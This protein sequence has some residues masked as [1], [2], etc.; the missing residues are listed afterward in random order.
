MKKSNLIL[1]PTDFSEASANAFRYA[2]RMAD[3][4]KSEILIVNA[5]I[6][7]ETG[8]EAAVTTLALRAQMEA[9]EKSIARFVDNGLAQVFPNLETAP[10]VTK[11]IRVG[12]AE[13]VIINIAKEQD[14][15]FILIGSRGENRNFVDKLIGSVAADVVKNALTPVMVIPENSDFRPITR[16]A[17]ATDAQTVDPFE[18]WKS[19]KLL[20]PFTP[21]VN[22]VHVDTEKEGDIKAWEMMDDLKEYFEGHAPGMQIKFHYL[23][24]EKLEDELNEFT[25]DHDIDLLI[26]YQPKRNFWQKLFYTSDTKKMAMKSPKPVL[27]Q[28]DK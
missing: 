1:F 12:S 14:V 5:V 25:E 4:L 26:M 7:M 24:G 21:I 16:V 28:K 17:Y 8:G 11:E 18:I 13:S 3:H 10:F 22:L 27:V 19:V 6:P 15:D 9:A 20:E 2:L 23:I